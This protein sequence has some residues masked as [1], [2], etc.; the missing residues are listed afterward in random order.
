MKPQRGQASL[1][2]PP[3]VIQASQTHPGCLL[4]SSQQC[5]FIPSAPAAFI[6][7]W[8]FS[9]PLN[10]PLAVEAGAASLSQKCTAGSTAQHS[11]AKGTS[12]VVQF[13]SWHAAASQPGFA[14]HD[15][16]KLSLLLPP[17]STCQLHTKSFVAPRQA[18]A[19]CMFRPAQATATLP[20]HLLG[21]QLL[22]VCIKSMAISPA[23][24]RGCLKPHPLCSHATG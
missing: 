6:T 20:P 4:S 15:R 22:G 11:T 7:L 3:K 17:A 14:G 5:L 1:S 19:C 24:A 16:G 23:A 9:F 8:S 2:L 18:A 21:S 13:K 12:D 10:I